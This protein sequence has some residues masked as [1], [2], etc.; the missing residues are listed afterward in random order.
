MAKYIVQP[1]QKVIVEAE[2]SELQL[3]LVEPLT[4][5]FHAIGNARVTDSDTV[6][7]LGCGMIGMGAVVRA[8]LRGAMVIAVDVDDAKLAIAGQ[9]GADYLI[10]TM[11]QEI[12]EADRITGGHGPSVVVEAAGNPQTYRSAFEK[13]AFAGRVVC[14]GY[15]KEDVALPTHLWVQKELQIMGSRNADPSD[16]DAV[17]SYLKKTNLDPGLLVSEIVTIEGASDAMRKWSEDPGSV[18]KILVK[19]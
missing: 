7:V 15:A 6:M 10:N 2:L 4:V 17:I 1:W 5:G 12:S 9:L 13:V 18:L 16:F 14:I 3:A 19:F 11:K 8:H